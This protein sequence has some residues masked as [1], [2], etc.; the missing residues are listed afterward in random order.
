L[1]RVA[2]M[3]SD[4]PF[5]DANGIHIRFSSSSGTPEQLWPLHTE[6]PPQFQLVIKRAT[7]LVRLTVPWQERWAEPAPPLS[8]I[9]AL[10]F[11]P[12][13]LGASARVVW[14]LFVIFPGLRGC[15]RLPAAP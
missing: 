9:P 15:D 14:F 3:F 8:P 1:E 13:R 12:L 10:L 6:I 2:R 5:H 4:P 11:H 7:G